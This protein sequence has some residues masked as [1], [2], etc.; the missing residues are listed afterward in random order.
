MKAPSKGIKPSTKPNKAS[1]SQNGKKSR[2]GTNCGAESFV[3]ELNPIPRQVI[4]LPLFNVGECCKKILVGLHYIPSA[5]LHDLKLEGHLQQGIFQS[6]QSLKNRGYIS[7][8]GIHYNLTDQ[9][10]A[11][12]EP[13][14]NM[15]KEYNSRATA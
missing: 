15:F 4:N 14:V 5:R 12:V 8:E 9:G 1:N 10:R 7:K 6:A 13:F 2:N 3:H 11:L